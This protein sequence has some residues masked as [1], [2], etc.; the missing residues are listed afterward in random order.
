MI[1]ALLCLSIFA[2]PA[3]GMHA[4]PP[5]DYWRSPVRCG[6]NCLYAYLALHG[7]PTT[8]EAISSKVPLG[9]EGATM[10]DLKRAANSLGVTSRIVK[11]TASGL[12]S[13][14]LPA[15]AHLHSRR[16]HYV[17]VLRVGSSEVTTMDMSSGVIT[18]LPSDRFLEMWSGHLLIPTT[19]RDG[20]NTAYWFGGG[21]AVLF[22]GLMRAAWGRGS[23]AKP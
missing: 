13:S 6:P 16:G 17:V 10:A 2:F 7:R 19:T 15:I 3:P 1:A 9:V 5:G 21:F 12:A 18:S 14:P 8:L 22:L 4:D 20:S 23:R 11:A